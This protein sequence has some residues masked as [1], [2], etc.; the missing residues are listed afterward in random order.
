ML[1]NRPKA[2]QPD[3]AP[4]KHTTPGSLDVPHFVQQPT[5]TVGDSVLRR[6]QILST[7]NLASFSLVDACQSLLGRRLEV[8]PPSAA[9]AFAG[10]APPPPTLDCVP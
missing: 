10:L 9:A 4:S 5:A 8:L 7:C 2:L 3:W 6:T 1:T